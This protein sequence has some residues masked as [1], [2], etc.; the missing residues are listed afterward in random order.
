MRRIHLEGHKDERIEFR[1]FSIHPTHLY[2]DH[3]ACDIRPHLTT[4]GFILFDDFIPK[5]FELLMYPKRSEKV[6]FIR[7][8]DFSNLFAFFWCS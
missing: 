1:G 2:I 8:N 5:S 6:F 4:V 7:G 3:A